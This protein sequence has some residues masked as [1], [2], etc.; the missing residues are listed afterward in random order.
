[1]WL[2]DT[3]GHHLEAGQHNPSFFSYTIY[4][5]KVMTGAMEE[6]DHV[7]LRQTSAG[8]S[9]SNT[10]EKVFEK[11]SPQIIERVTAQ[12]DVS[13]ESFAHLD[14]REINRKIDIR[15]IPMITILYLLSF[16]DRGR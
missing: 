4:S 5:S 14:I 7:E 1:M 10:S 9:S 6:H 3:R 8:T 12:E 11:G 13:L 2:R 16:L 15:I